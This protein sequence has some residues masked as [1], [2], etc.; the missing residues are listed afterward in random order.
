MGMDTVLTEGSAGMKSKHSGN[1]EDLHNLV[2]MT[3]K[4]GSEEFV[5]QGTPVLPLVQEDDLEKAEVSKE[6]SDMLRAQIFKSY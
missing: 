6:A 3:G 5:N 2:H 4:I 1:P